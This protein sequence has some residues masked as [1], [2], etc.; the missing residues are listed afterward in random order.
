[1]RIVATNDFTADV[2]RIACP[3]LVLMGESG[4][5]GYA[6]NGNQALAEEFL[7]LAANATLELVADG[8]GTYCMIEQPAATAQAVIDFI[9]GL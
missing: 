1:M 8:G 6:E 4:H 2:G 3:V 5:L 9:D 7:A